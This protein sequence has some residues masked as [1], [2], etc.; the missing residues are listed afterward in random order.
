MVVY[1]CEWNDTATVKGMF[2]LQSNLPRQRI[3]G[4]W[5]IGNCCSDRIEKSSGS[6][7]VKDQPG[8][9]TR[10]FSG[11]I[12]T[13]HC[14]CIISRTNFRVWSQFKT[15]LVVAILLAH[16]NKGEAIKYLLLLAF[17]IFLFQDNCLN[18]CKKITPK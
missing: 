11:R 7:G 14:K 9:L 16:N 2:H 3:D 12:A 18:S 6:P 4:Y 15:K 10:P 1:K 13:L 5:C 17:V 8:L